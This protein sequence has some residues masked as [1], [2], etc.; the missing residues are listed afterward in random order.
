MRQYL[1]KTPTASEH[2]TQLI[3]YFH[4]EGPNGIHL[5]LVV[6]P[7]GPSA[8]TMV[9]ELACFKQRHVNIKIRYPT[10]MA[11]S[12]LQQS[13]QGLAFLHSLDI[14]HGDFQPGNILFT[15]DL[16]NISQ[17]EELAQS[18][19]YQYEQFLLQ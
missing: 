2:V 3:D 17:E 12:L 13:L 6:E 11:K 9:E 15:I 4:H 1:S 7:M 16:S 5:C 10:W 18:D 8:N 14:A 19:Q